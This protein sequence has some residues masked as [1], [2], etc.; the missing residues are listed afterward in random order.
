MQYV[1][2]ENSGENILNIE[3]ENYKY[4]FRVKRHSVGDIIN[5]RNLKDNKLYEYKVD[6]VSKKDAI[7]SLQ[8]TTNDELTSDSSLVLGW[9]VIDPK[10][11]EKTLP[12]LNEIG[13]KKICFIY[14]DYSQKNFKINA[15]RFEKILINS[16]MQCGRTDL[17]EFEIYENLTSFK[18]KFPNSYLFNFTNN[19]ILNSKNE[20][21]EIV[22]GCE[23]GFSKKELALY[24]DKNIVGVNISNILRSETAAVSV[25]SMLLG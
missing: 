19:N 23:G 15:Q 12:F 4:L 14:G 10:T 2:D 17:I 25:C 22:I 9:L 7:L 8:K 21:N 16:C 5:F 18:N 3:D 24:Q 6:T 1:Y 11:I 20:I 13:I